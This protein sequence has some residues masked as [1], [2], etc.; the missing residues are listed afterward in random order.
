MDRVWQLETDIF[1]GTPGF[2]FA[3]M[4]EIVE[5]AEDPTALHPEIQRQAANIRTDLDRFSALEISSL[6]RH[7][8]CVGRKACRAH[9][10]LFGPGVPADPPWDPIPDPRTTGPPVGARLPRLRAARAAVPATIEARALQASALRRIWSTLFDRR[11]WTS[12]VYVPLL[13]PILVLVPFLVVRSHQRS[14]RIN[15]LVESLSQGSRD[16]ETM[17]RL[18]E[19]TP[20]PLTGV[21]AEEVRSLDEPDFKGFEILQDSRIVDLR[22]WKPVGYRKI[23]LGSWVYAYRR[24]KIAKQSKSGAKSLRIVLLPTSP[25]TVVRFPRQQLEPKLLKT[26]MDNSATG[27]KECRWQASFDFQKVAAGEFV[28]LIVEYGSPGQYLQR[29]DDSTA[30]SFPVQAETAELTTWILM[31]EGREYGGFRIIRYQTGKPDEVEAVKVVTEYL[32]EDFTIL[33][34]KLVSLKPG[35]TYEVS[36]AY[37]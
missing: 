18:L 24:L 29:G 22:R 26:A 20:A 8:Y 6:V 12:Y 13:V 37:R 28:D 5:P 21:V 23:D 7:G 32:A 25:E 2:V 30:L 14:Q 36:W 33:A 17:S 35:Y 4:T 15:H 9:P 10:E 27:E 31:P 19:H 11:D 1:Q 3:P 16:L 34:F